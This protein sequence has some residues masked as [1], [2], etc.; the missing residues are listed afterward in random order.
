MSTRQRINRKGLTIRELAEQT[1]YSRATIARATSM[2]RDEWLQQKADER[3]A[4]RRYH[5]DEGNSWTETAKHFKLSYETVKARAYRAR[6][7]RAAEVE[8]EA[9]RERE[10]VEPPL[11][12]LETLR[13]A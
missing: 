3:E 12:P 11:I 9:E 4:I 6:K 7:E 13:S 10:K 5:D 1:G 8:A 2:S